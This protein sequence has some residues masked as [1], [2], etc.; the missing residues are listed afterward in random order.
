[1][2]LK[3]KPINAINQ[4]FKVNCKIDTKVMLI[5]GMYVCMH[6]L[7]YLV[8]SFLVVYDYHTLRS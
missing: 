8:L 4:Y 5:N 7:A 2:L 3:L 1:M 6:G